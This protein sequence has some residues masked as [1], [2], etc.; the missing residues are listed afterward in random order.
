MTRSR[1]LGART[2][3]TSRVVGPSGSPRRRAA[4]SRPSTS[5]ATP[6]CEEFGIDIAAPFAAYRDLLFFGSHS[7]MPP[8]QRWAFLS[9]GRTNRPVDI[10]KIFEEAAQDFQRRRREIVGLAINRRPLAMEI[11]LASEPAS[12]QAPPSAGAAIGLL[13]PSH[14]LVASSSLLRGPDLF[15][16]RSS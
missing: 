13:A 3:R 2:E 6:G 10:G 14:R 4:R 8:D 11:K 16:P 15:G 1:R 9:A 12:A 7:V 5:A